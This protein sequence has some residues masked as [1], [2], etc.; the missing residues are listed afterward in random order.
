MALHRLTA[1]LLTARLLAATAREWRVG[2]PDSAR[3]QGRNSAE[4]RRVDSGKLASHHL[5]AG[6]GGGEP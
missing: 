4:A 2:A 6:R 5:C 3:R 1:P